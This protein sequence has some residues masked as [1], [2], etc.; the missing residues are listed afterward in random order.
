[1]FGFNSR[2]VETQVK[3]QVC[4]MLGIYGEVALC[5]VHILHD[6]LDWRPPQPLTLKHISSQA[7]A[8]AKIEVK[9]SYRVQSL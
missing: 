3:F 8:E 6:V 5:G 1:M 2:L 9:N 7:S 4:C